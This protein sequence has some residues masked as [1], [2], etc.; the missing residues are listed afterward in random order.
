MNIQD[1]HKKYM[2]RCIELAQTA[3][4]NTYENPVVG[5]VIVHNDKIIGEGYH[6]K[7]G[8]PHAEVNAINSVKNQELL[9]ESTIYVSLEPCSHIGK[10][11][12]C[13]TLII[14]KKI[15]RVVIGTIDSFSKVQGR[16]MKMLQDAGIEVITGVLESECREL[17]K[18]FFTFHEKKR[19][20]VILK[21]AQTLDGFI[22]SDGKYSNESWITNNVSKILVHKWRTEEPAILVGRITAEKDNPKLNV[23]EWTGNNP[24]R[25]TIDVKNVLPSDLNLFDNSQPT[26]V[27]SNIDKEISPNL[28]YV[29]IDSTQ[30]LVPQILNHLYSVG[31]QSLIVE[32]GESILSQFIEAGLWDEA[33]VFV[34][35]KLFVSGVKA[36]LINKLPNEKYKIFDSKLFIYKNKY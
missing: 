16:G 26:I 15:P 13:S 20:Y 28:K 3:L 1:K 22:D 19:P 8:E 5:A 32:G 25:I 4:G 2:Q 14:N 10:T 27:F 30:K 24:L 21:W 12:A 11:P 33:R 29:K 6:C 9:K 17:N 18:R 35:N 36:P 31:I 23:R 7:A 34:G